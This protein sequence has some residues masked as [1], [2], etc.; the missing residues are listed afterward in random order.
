MLVEGASNKD[1]LLTGR[2]SNNNLVHF[3]GC[4]ELVGTIADVTLVDCKGFYYIGQLA[5]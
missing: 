1:G 2:L 4:S 5:E 3:K